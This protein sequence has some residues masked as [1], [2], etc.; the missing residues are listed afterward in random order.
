MSATRFDELPSAVGQLSIR[1]SN[2]RLK[3]INTEMSSLSSCATIGYQTIACEVVSVQI[4]AR[5]N[6][7]GHVLMDGCCSRVFSASSTQNTFLIFR[8]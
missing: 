5:I 7:T 1:Q 6:I 8:V 3:H 2:Q 4:M